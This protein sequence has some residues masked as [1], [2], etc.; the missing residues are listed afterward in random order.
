MRKLALTLAAALLVAAPADASFPGRNG[1]LA[2]TFQACENQ[3]YIRSLSISGRDLGTLV[4]CA[5]GRRD[6]DL[7][8]EPGPDVYGP[9][10]SA[11][12]KRMLFARGLSGYQQLATVAA[13]GSDERIVPEGTPHA[14]DDYPGPS[15]SPDDR[16]V[17]VSRDG[18]IYVGGVDGGGLRVLRAKVPCARDGGFCAVF[19]APRWSPDGRKLAVAASGLHPGLLLIDPGSGRTIRR[20]AKGFSGAADWSPDGRRLAFT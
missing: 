8:N 5:L 17:A 16:Q 11:N 20:L 13:D 18:S 10:W 19:Y 4:P 7:G 3:T 12:G 14:T 6:P 2:V 9:D 1:K 15:I